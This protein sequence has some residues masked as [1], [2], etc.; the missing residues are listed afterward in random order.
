MEHQLSVRFL[1]EDEDMI[2]VEARAS[3]CGFSGITQFYTTWEA[4]AT[5]A[6]NL[7]GFPGDAGRKSL[8]HGGVL[9]G[10][11]YL[12]VA[13]SALDTKGH[14]ACRV[15][16]ESNGGDSADCNNK[17]ELEMGVEPGAVDGFV[18]ELTTLVREKSG[19]ARLQGVEKVWV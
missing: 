12:G 15:V 8:F 3:S 6:R 5:W 18:R 9:D 4:L 7:E 19:A 11:G 16:M 13:V 17:V 10:Y 14:C 1:L 2:M